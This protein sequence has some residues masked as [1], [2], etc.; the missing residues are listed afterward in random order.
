MR[1]EV[2]DPDN[3]LYLLSAPKSNHFTYYSMFTS[4][5]EEF[6][7]PDAPSWFAYMREWKEQLQHPLEV[8]LIKK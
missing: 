2:S 7:Y 1:Q 8:K 3:Y 5:K 6:G 4:R